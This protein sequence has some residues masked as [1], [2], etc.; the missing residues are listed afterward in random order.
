MYKETLEQV[1]KCAQRAR[2]AFITRSPSVLLFLLLL[3]LLRRCRR[4][5]L[6]YQQVEEKESDGGCVG[7]R[8]HSSVQRRK[9]NIFVR[10][11][12]LARKLLTASPL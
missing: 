12:R 8:P 5:Q 2:A 7:G 6:V 9:L 1:P 11:R 4:V 3:L 10:G